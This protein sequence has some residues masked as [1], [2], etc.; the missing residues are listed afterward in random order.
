IPKHTATSLASAKSWRPIS[1][2]PVLGKVLEKLMIQRVLYDL[3]S[4]GLLSD[5]QHGFTPK[6]STSSAISQLVDHMKSTVDDDHLGAI[7]SLDVSGAF[8]HAFWPAI[9]CRLKELG[10]PHNVLHLLR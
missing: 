1:L 10:S 7:I 8:D 6:K 2:L 9:L 4:R 5:K 3:R